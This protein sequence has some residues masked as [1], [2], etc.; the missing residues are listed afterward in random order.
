MEAPGRNTVSHNSAL[1]QVFPLGD[2]NGYVRGGRYCNTLGH[3]VRLWS[4]STN[5]SCWHECGDCH[6]CNS[7]VCVHTCFHFGNNIRHVRDARFRNMGSC[8]RNTESFYSNT[9]SSKVLFFL[10]VQA[11]C[12]PMQRRKFV[13]CLFV[14]S[15]SGLF[16]VPKEEEGLPDSHFWFLG[17]S[18]LF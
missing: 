8:S 15:F 2:N 6:R 11:C 18:C 5:L 10:E 12:S 16:P 9:C 1:L 4:S 17:F 3:S 13:P 7:A 14:F